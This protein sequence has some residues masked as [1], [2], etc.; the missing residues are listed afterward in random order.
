MSAIKQNAPWSVK[1]IERDARETAKEAAKREG[2]TV[3]EWLNQI[4]YSAG[5]A[6]ETE[7]NIEGLKIRDLV[8]AIEHL[9][10]RVSEADDATAKAVGDLSRN[11]GTV[12]ERVQRLERA[13]PQEGSNEDLAARVEKL[14]AGGGGRSR[15]EAL[16][17]LEKAVGQVAVQFNTQHTASLARIDANEKQLQEL[18]RRLDEGAGGGDADVSAVNYLKDSID[19]LSTRITR[20]ERIAAEAQKLQGAANGSA[21]P[22]FIE[23]T[24]A[25]LRVLGEEI[26]RGGDQIGALEATIGKLSEQIEAAERRSAEGVQKVAETIA[27]VRKQFETAEGEDAGASRDEI[28][29]AIAEASRQTDVKITALQDSF[30]D[31]IS[32]LEALDA[33]EAIENIADDDDDIDGFARDNFVEPAAEAT[34]LAADIT[35]EIADDDLGA[36]EVAE[37]PADEIEARTDAAAESETD[38]SFDFDLDDD[39]G[40]TPPSAQQQSADDILSEVQ[41]VFGLGDAETIQKPEQAETTAVQDSA[42]SEGETDQSAETAGD[43][44]DAI[45]ADLEALGSDEEA[46]GSDEETQLSKAKTAALNTEPAPQ[47]AKEPE[48][49]EAPAEEGDKED[50]LAAARRK[51]KETA[52]QQAEENAKPKRRKLTP[53]QKAIL[54]ARARRKRLAAMRGETDAQTSATPEAGNEKKAAPDEQSIAFAEAEETG[55]ETE[56]GNAAGPLAKFAALG[57]AF[58]ALR[59]R[60]SKNKSDEQDEDAD[61]P[62]AE[63]VTEP[64]V[65]EEEPPAAEPAAEIEDGE[66]ERKGNKDRAALENLKATASARPVTMALGVAILLAVAALFFLVKDLVFKSPEQISQPPVAAVTPAP[67]ADTGASDAGNPGLRDE[68]ALIVPAAPTVNPRDLY[69]EAM[70]ALNAATNEEETTAAIGKLNES[71]V[72]GHPPAQLQL[73]EL[74]KLGQGVEQDL[75]QARTWFRRSANGGNVLAMHRIGVMTARGD[76]GLADTEEAIG[77]FELAANRGLVDSQYNLGAIYHPSNDGSASNVQDAAKAYY[78]YSLA[79]N[80]GD[81]QAAP[82]AASVA[83]S[84][85]A[86]QRQEIDAA[87]ATWSAEAADPISNE[88]APAT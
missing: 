68:E 34:G 2:M 28:D 82:L 8:T 6:E 32:R 88:L 19:G 61:E 30:D 18:A 75:G 36:I 16:K 31:M 29:A 71:A 56:K 38:D 57:G 74:Y 85:T 23:R 43:D 25:R 84:L 66:N 65:D 55:A 59:G 44:L 80:N 62:E 15:V 78:W 35:D 53:K 86:P 58:A 50:Y 46:L 77:W 7:G 41:D 11:V 14:E 1:G 39:E 13:K 22:E 40:V 60:F 4:I 83:A 76:G 27:D 81:E 9:N 72:L 52:Q 87:I 45:L 67:S 12:L 69:M 20:A 73:G 64:I 51:A 42:A 48:E 33:D 17:A 49:A 21:D 54:A 47:I 5:D 37:E 70:T 63:A 26:K 24:G 3:G 10:K 79:A